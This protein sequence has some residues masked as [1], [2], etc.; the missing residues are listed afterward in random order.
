MF[1]S[2]HFIDQQTYHL[3]LFMDENWN[4]KSSL[5]SYGHDIEA[6]WLLLQCAEVIEQ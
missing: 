5:I 1:L 6:A 4:V 2:N 3:H